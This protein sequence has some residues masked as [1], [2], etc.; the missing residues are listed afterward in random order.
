MW[1][2][3]LNYNLF[4]NLILDFPWN[5]PFLSKNKIKM[6]KKYKTISNLVGKNW[7]KKELNAWKNQTGILDKI[8]NSIVS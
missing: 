5:R 7:L 4:Y 2:H 6:K 8:E 3:N 1:N